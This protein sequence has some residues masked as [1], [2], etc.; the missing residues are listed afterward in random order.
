VRGNVLGFDPESNVGAISGHDGNRYNFATQDWQDRR[1]PNRGDLADFVIEDGRAAHIY[2]V[3]QE[4]VPPT[5]IEFLFSPRGRISRSQYWLKWTLPVFA[6]NIALALAIFAA[7]R[8]HSTT[9]GIVFA[10]GY[11]ALNIVLVWP[12]LA[13]LIKR[14]HDR[15]WPWPFMLLTFVPLVQFW[16]LVEYWFLPGT[17]G[18]NR[19]GPD[20]VPRQWR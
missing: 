16:P 9:L 2:L 12:S 19:F 11:V 18:S 10:A 17:I 13:I 4:Y 7:E 3:E 1:R 14:G 20:P 5:L 15:D 8:A 6:I